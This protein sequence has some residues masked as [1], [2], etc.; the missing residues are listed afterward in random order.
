MPPF[1]FSAKVETEPGA[2]DIT[3]CRIG[4]HGRP[5]EIAG[6]ILWREGGERIHTSPSCQGTSPNANDTRM[7]LL[8]V[9]VPSRLTIPWEIFSDEFE[10]CSRA[11]CPDQIPSIAL[12]TK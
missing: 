1:Q 2:R 4:P 3:L 10:R 9:P 6:F 12:D 8:Q 11:S 5:V 7:R